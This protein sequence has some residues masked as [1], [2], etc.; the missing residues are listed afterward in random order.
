M[1]CL[2]AMHDDHPKDTKSYVF[3]LRLMNQSTK[4]T[5]D[6]VRC[7]VSTLARVTC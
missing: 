7:I 2:L 6:E 5:F 3:L 4:S 1:T